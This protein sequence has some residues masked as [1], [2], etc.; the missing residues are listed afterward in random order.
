MSKTTKESA[1]KELQGKSVEELKEV[2]KTLQLQL[3]E[4]Q[5]L[6][7]HHQTMATKAHGAFE[8]I[9]QLI[10]KEEV[11]KLAAEQQPDIENKDNGE[12]VEG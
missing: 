4:H 9:L 1:T 6:A 5:R 10:P 12:L 2:A 7:T 8:V 11:E 3:Q